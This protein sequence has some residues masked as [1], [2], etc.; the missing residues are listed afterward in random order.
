MMTATIA[1]PPRIATL[2]IVRG[3]AVMGILAMNIVAFGMPPE[4]YMNPL[5]YGVDGTADLASWAFSFVLIDGKMRGLFSFLFGASMLLV[6]HKADAKGESPARVHFR[7]M[8][9][10]LVFGLGHFYFIW[11]GDILTGYAL[12]GMIAWFFRNSQPRKLLRWAVGLI[13]VQFLLFAFFAFG[14]HFVSAAASAPHP[15]PEMVRQ[16]T[17]MQEGLAIPTDDQLGETMRLFGASWLDHARH[18]LTEKTFNPVVMLAFFGWETLAYMLL[19]MAS[20]RNGFL[21]GEW[22]DSTYRRTAIRGFAIG[23]PVYA[24]LAAWLW[25][26]GF[27]VPMLMTLGMAATVIFR[28]VM[29]IATAALVILLT[30]RRGPLVER[31]AAAGRAAFTNYLGTSIAMTALFYG[32][33]LGWFG[34]MSRIELWL[35][36]FAMWA[37]M[38]VWSKPWLDRFQYG[39]FEWLWRSLSRWS[40]QPMRRAAPAAAAE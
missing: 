30:R 10:L 27:S 33:G 1:A 40:P 5:A 7:R 26:D 38:L 18:Q 11:Y 21:T 36:V 19:G 14:F 2:D 39:P 12:I 13:A 15:D 4:A 25:I 37:L 6:I 34:T 29:V 17:E 32:W 22:D 24:L 20:L 31:I 23:I 3:V 35:V 16:W 9:W 8:I 28:P